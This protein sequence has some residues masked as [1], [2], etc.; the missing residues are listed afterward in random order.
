MA[1]RRA[2]T[3]TLAPALAP[4]QACSGALQQ[5]EE[6]LADLLDACEG[7]GVAQL[8]HLQQLPP[9]AG[10]R[11]FAGLAADDPPPAASTAP[12][13]DAERRPR[14]RAARMT[15]PSPGNAQPMRPAA[16]PLAAA[17]STPAS[18]GPANTQRAVPNDTP[19][20]ATAGFIDTRATPS[21]S[22]SAAFVRLAGALADG[23]AARLQDAGALITALLQRH[24]APRAPARLRGIGAAEPAPMRPQGHSARTDTGTVAARPG[25][26]PSTLH[27]TA[28]GATHDRGAQR[29]QAFERAPWPAPP[30]GRSDP[31]ES[32]AADKVPASRAPSKPG[33]AGALASG[34]ATQHRTQR[35]SPLADAASDAARLLR[36]GDEALRTLV[37]PLFMRATPFAMPSAV[38]PPT[39]PTATAAARGRTQPPLLR[40]PS[41]LLAGALA[42]DSHKGGGKSTAG[43]SGAG[44]V[45]PVAG[46]SPLDSA[47]DLAS[48]LDRLLRE[49]AWLRGVDLT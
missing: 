18:A 1:E 7:A 26:Q 31:A 38:M 45:Q 9:A 48:G 30:S 40:A 4:F 37:A 39:D 27:D 33:Q 20:A 21:P 14:A 2:P 41:R 32:L 24:P 46:T 35:A 29:G 42:D 3:A 43:K 8:G 47:A 12:A 28:F 25:G 5:V 34:L 22:E 10:F 15:S 44:P 6:R 16:V 19:G 49:Q 17:V 13:Q 36:S 23:S 11:P